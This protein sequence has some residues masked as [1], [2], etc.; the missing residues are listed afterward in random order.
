MSPDFGRVQGEPYDLADCAP[1]IG[2]QHWTQVTWHSTTDL[3][4][5][6]GKP[7]T[8]RFELYQAKLFGLEFE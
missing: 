3:G 5:E 2:D 6:E 7:V 4:I 8:L 1:I